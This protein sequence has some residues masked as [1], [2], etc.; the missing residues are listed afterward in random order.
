[1][2]Y[3]VQILEYKNRRRKLP[4]PERQH[5][6]DRSSSKHYMEIFTQTIRTYHHAGSLTFTVLV[7]HSSLACA[8]AYAAIA[9]QLHYADYLLRQNTVKQEF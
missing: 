7:A 8:V 1:M 9:S 3:S 5:Y 2:I 6:Q 4:W